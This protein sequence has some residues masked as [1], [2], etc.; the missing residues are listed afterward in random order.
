MSSNRGRYTDGKHEPKYTQDGT[1]CEGERGRGKEEGEKGG[2]GEGEG[3]RGRGKG[4]GEVEWLHRVTWSNLDG[5]GE[6]AKVLPCK[7][8]TI[9]SSIHFLN[10]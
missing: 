10:E 2:K 1:D 4:G 8:F 6:E 5:E 3:K 7:D 9:H